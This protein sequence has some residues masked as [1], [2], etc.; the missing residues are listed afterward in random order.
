MM[1]RAHSR[2]CLNPCRKPGSSVYCGFMVL[3][4]GNLGLQFRVWFYTAGAY[5]ADSKNNNA[6]SAFP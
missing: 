1:A 5:T 6:Q 4:L 2:S 3:G